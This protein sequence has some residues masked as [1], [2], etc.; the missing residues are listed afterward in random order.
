MTWILEK[1]RVTMQ[2]HIIQYVRYERHSKTV[3]ST[4]PWRENEG[5]AQVDEQGVSS[6]AGGDCCAAQ[7]SD[8]SLQRFGILIGAE[9][10]E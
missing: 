9:A 1:R 3:V 10:N 6:L 7:L 8:L 2:K 5:T 4:S